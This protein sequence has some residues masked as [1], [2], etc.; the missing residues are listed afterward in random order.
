MLVVNYTTIEM[1][2]YNKEVL[3]LQKLTFYFSF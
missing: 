3:A 2:K 1:M